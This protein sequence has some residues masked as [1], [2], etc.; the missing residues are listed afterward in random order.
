MIYF[1]S[2]RESKNFYFP[3][4]FIYQSFKLENIAF[5]VTS[6]VTVFILFTSSFFTNLISRPVATHTSPLIEM[7]YATADQVYGKIT[8]L[9][10]LTVT[11][12]E[13]IPYKPV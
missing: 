12:L 8:W 9:I 7:V 3:Q 13:W 5:S 2:C 10:N 6:L 4:L 1:C 11:L